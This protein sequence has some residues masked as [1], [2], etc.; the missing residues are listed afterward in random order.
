MI[1]AALEHRIRQALKEQNGSVA[2]IEEANSAADS[3]LD[4]LRFGGIHEYRLGEI[5]P[6]VTE[7]TEDDKLL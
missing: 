7:L 3:P 5:P 6:H 1:Y 4:F 2:Y